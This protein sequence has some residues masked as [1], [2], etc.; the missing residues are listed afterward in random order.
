LS[1]VGQNFAPFHRKTQ[2]KSASL[3]RRCPQKA[4]AIAPSFDAFVTQ[5]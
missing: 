4:A 5:K 1:Y 3:A 2:K